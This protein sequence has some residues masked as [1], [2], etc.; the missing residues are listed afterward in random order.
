MLN[1]AS[2]SLALEIIVFH[3]FYGFEILPDKIEL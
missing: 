3:N 2:K 1:G